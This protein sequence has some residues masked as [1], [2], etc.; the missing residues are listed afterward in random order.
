MP[1]QELVQK[2]REIMKKSYCN[3]ISISDEHIIESD[4]NLKF[5]LDYLIPK[6]VQENGV[7]FTF[8]IKIRD[9]A[10]IT[11]S[12]NGKL[13]NKTGVGDFTRETIEK[14]KELIEKRQKF[15]IKL[16]AN[17]LIKLEQI[18]ISL[19]PLRKVIRK[20]ID[21]DY[22]IDNLKKS[23]TDKEI[24]YINLLK[25]FGYLRIDKEKY[26]LDNEY[27]TK[28]E[29]K[30]KQ[31]ERQ[32]EQIVSDVFAEHFN[33][34]IQELGNTTIVPFVGILTTLCNLI[35]ELNRNLNLN[36]T[37][38][39]SFYNEHYSSGQ[40]VYDFQDKVVD[41]SKCKLLE[42]NEEKKSV[43]LPVELFQNLITKFKSE[44][45]QKQLR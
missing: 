36:L 22:R 14:Y 27:I 11:M 13:I 10:F 37:S 32:I 42:Y 24:K 34:I 7:E 33:Y 28:L 25:T 3:G 29:K 39:Y 2:T 17:Q 23:F 21:S 19:T 12:K 38:L 9:I 35:L 45:I 30:I 40:S 8:Y 20:F 18:H 31:K 1:T 43:T 26:T 5:H 16:F 44:F 41:M 15:I 4:K 6:K